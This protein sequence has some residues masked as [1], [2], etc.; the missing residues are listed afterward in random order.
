MAG[1]IRSIQVSDFRR[2]IEDPS[3]TAYP[4]FDA[5]NALD[6]T[7]CLMDHT[8][9][10]T[11]QSR[12]T[13]ASTPASDVVVRFQCAS[14]PRTSA[15]DP[16]LEVASLWQGHMAGCM[17]L[18]G[19]VSEKEQTGREQNFPRKMGSAGERW[20]SITRHRT[21]PLMRSC[22]PMLRHSLVR[23]RRVE[24]CRGIKKALIM[25][26]YSAALPTKA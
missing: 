14:A 1:A 20:R 13:L 10:V 4:I 11:R 16:Q 17:D 18:A 25:P 9:T 19:Q 23:Q 26:I 5:Y 7:K 22:M 15:N 8:L 6:A 24:Q 2:L 21:D 3:R 12:P